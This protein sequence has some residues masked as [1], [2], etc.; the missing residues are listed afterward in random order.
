MEKSGGG[1]QEGPRLGYP[2]QGLRDQVLVLGNEGAGLRPEVREACTLLA[3]IPAHDRNQ[4]RSLNLSVA[5]GIAL[6]HLAPRGG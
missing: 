2:K 4:G 5:A 3:S 6:A 1:S